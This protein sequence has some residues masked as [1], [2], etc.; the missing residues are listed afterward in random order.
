MWPPPDQ[1]RLPVEITAFNTL[2]L[3]GSGIL[4]YV[5]NKSLANGD[6]AKAKK[7]LGL[8]ILLG[9]LF[10]LIQGYEWMQMLGHGLSLTSSTYGS[11]FYTIIGCHAIHVVAALLILVKV[12]LSFSKTTF[13]RTTYWGVQVFWYFVVGVWPVLYVLVYLS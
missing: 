5:S 8:G 1:P 11:F 3:V 7:Q 6:E 10:V 12:Y 2:F 4:V 9:S 13:K